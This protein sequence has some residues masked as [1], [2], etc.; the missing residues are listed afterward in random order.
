MTSETTQ[1]KLKYEQEF[2]RFTFV[3]CSFQ[4]LQET[5]RQLFGWNSTVSFQLQYVDDEQDV[6][7]IGSDE[8]LKCA[9]ELNEHFLRLTLLKTQD[10]VCN[11]SQYLQLIFIR[12]V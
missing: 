12:S 6:I 5:I 4:K 9:I 2:R 10:K 7:T 8:E 3:G 1:I 11:F